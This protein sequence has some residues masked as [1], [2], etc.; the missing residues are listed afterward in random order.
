MYSD[1]YFGMANLSETYISFYPICWYL[2]PILGATIMFLRPNRV[3]KHLRPVPSPIAR[4]LNPFLMTTQMFVVF[5]FCRVAFLTLLQGS[6]PGEATSC[7]RQAPARNWSAETQFKIKSQAFSVMI[8]G[9]HRACI[10][11][12]KEAIDAYCQVPS[13]ANVYIT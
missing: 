7:G 11:I 10:P 6:H 13:V 2:L 12:M 8:H 5:Y 4:L 9:F 3:V 1:V